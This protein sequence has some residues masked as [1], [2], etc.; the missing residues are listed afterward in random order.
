MRIPIK[1]VSTSGKLNAH[2][3]SRTGDHLIPEPLTTLIGIR[4]KNTRR[5]CRIIYTRE[6]QVRIQSFQL[7]LMKFPH[8][9][10]HKAAW[11]LDLNDSRWFVHV[12]VLSWGSLSKQ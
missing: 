5:I 12:R 7:H 4:R 10:D 11:F 1:V 2:A 9:V 3:L 6:D 8:H